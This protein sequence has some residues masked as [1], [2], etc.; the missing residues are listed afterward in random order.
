MSSES[1]SVVSLIEFSVSHIELHSLE[2]K[3]YC[4]RFQDT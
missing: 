1:S 4:N 2:I 3:K